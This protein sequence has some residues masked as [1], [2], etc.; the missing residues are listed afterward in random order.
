MDAIRR[1]LLAVVQQALDDGLTM[2][3][4][5]RRAGQRRTWLQDHVRAWEGK[6]R[7][8]AEPTI[9]TLVSLAGGLGMSLGDLLGPDLLSLP[10]R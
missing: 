3:E 5:E 2:A 1:R 4:I 9:S 8:G 10:P 7:R 6:G